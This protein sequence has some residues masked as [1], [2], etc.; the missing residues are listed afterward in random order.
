MLAFTSR[1][2]MGTLPVTIDA[3][4]DEL[5]IPAGLAEM[6]GSFGKTM[7][8]NGCAGVYPALVVMGL[9]ATLQIPIDGTF[10]LP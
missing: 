6:V 8:M 10:I 7:G 1:S 5:H 4:V 3:M 2:S 9:A